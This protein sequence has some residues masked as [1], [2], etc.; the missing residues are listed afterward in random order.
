MAMIFNKVT[1]GYIN[2]LFLPLLWGIQCL[3]NQGN[4]LSNF[5]SAKQENIHFFIGFL[6][7]FSEL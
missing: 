3:P 1:C 6:Q 7:L 5:V 2:V 4:S